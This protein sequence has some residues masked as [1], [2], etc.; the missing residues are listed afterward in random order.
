MRNIDDIKNDV[1]KHNLARYTG[2]FTPQQWWDKDAD[3]SVEL[4]EANYNL[5]F[6]KLRK[7]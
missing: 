4:W 7:G 1:I 2:E 5:R 6:K 3:L